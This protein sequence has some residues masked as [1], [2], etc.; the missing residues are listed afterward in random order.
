MCGQTHKHT[1]AHTL[2]LINTQTH[3][4]RFDCQRS[5][6]VKSVERSCNVSAFSRAFTR[7]SNS[8]PRLY[9]DRG[10]HVFVRSFSSLRFPRLFYFR[11]QHGRLSGAI[12]RTNFT[13]QIIKQTKFFIHPVVWRA[14]AELLAEFLKK[15]DD[16]SASLQTNCEHSKASAEMFLADIKLFQSVCECVSVHTLDSWAA[17]VIVRV[18]CL[19]SVFKKNKK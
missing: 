19:V 14:S 6:G 12:L 17:F 1:H 13:S 7:Y 2:F 10:V 15:Q 3:T 18:L 11:E 8:S 5:V 9:R 16:G 4:H